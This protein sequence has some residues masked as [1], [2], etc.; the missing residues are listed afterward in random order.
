MT[1]S[2]EED[3]IRKMIDKDGAYVYLLTVSLTSIS[4]FY[5]FTICICITLCEENRLYLVIIED[6]S[7]LYNTN[8]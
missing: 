1:N 2:T 4:I 6:V 3:L 5:Q 8:Q 7:I